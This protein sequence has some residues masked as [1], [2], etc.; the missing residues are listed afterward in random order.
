MVSALFNSLQKVKKESVALFDFDGTL[1]KK[2]S[3]ILFIKFCVGK[4]TFRLGSLFLS[5]I[6]LLYKFKI[7]SNYRA[8]QIVLSFFF[9]DWDI[10][11]F[12]KFGNDFAL[13]CIPDILRRDAL[14]RL[15]WHM[16][17]GHRIIIV[18]ASGENWIKAW[19]DKMGVELIGT[20]LEVNN[21]KITGKFKSPNCHGIEKVNRLRSYVQLEKY[22][23]YAYGDTSGDKPFLELAD[24]KFYKTFHQ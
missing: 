23:I 6:I 8:K 7:I 24:E 4:N 21:N 16:E 11:K 20:R 14:L 15:R 17:N 19:T 22:Y 9:K 5:P 13:Q 10:G 1:T 3:L 18:T 2:D 12:Q